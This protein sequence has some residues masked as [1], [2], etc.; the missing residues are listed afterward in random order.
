MGRGDQRSPL[1]ILIIMINK[2]SINGERSEH[3]GYRVVGKKN[4]AITG[5]ETSLKRKSGQPC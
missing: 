1:P 4:Y 5:I 2:I 3:Q